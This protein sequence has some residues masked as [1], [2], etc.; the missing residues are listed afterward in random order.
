MCQEETA[1]NAEHQPRPAA[2]A[3]PPQGPGRRGERT[4]QSL[5]SW[6]SRSCVRGR[7]PSRLHLTAAVW[8]WSLGSGI[9][10][11]SGSS[12]PGGE[13]A[14]GEGPPP[15]SPLPAGIQGFAQHP[16]PAA[17]A[18][19]SRSSVPPRC[20]LAYF[21]RREDEGKGWVSPALLLPTLS[22]STPTYSSCSPISS[23]AF[24]K[25]STSSC[26]FVTSSLSFLL[27]V[28][29]CGTREGRVGVP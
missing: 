27:T 10:R 25:D 22:E 24:L 7:L 11:S 5:L 29:F 18:S 13:T 15:A 20:P 4:Q 17:G 23:R 19:P 14:S 9:P 12:E 16:P 3:P 28:G 1:R 26:S 8:G 21:C 2:K 6:L